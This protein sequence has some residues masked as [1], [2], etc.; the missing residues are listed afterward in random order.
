LSYRLEFISW[1]NIAVSFLPRAL[2]KTAETTMPKEGK[3]IKG[4][5]NDRQLP[6]SPSEKQSEEQRNVQKM[7]IY[8]GEISA[9][10]TR[11]TRV[12]SSIIP[13]N[14]HFATATPTSHWGRQPT[15]KNFPN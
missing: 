10:H 14:F 11:P 5:L 13:P 7:S 8:Y 6:S 2:V 15:V 12:T 4:G 1:A 9:G 3:S